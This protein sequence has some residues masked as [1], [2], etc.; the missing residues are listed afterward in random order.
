[1]AGFAVIAFLSLVGHNLASPES[2]IRPGR[3]FDPLVRETFAT[4]TDPA[5]RMTVL[6]TVNGKGP[7]P[8]TVD[9]GA[10]RSV[11]SDRLATELGISA[12]GTVTIEGLVGPDQ[13]DSVRLDHVSVGSTHQYA[14]D[15]AVLPAT[16]LG[17][18]GFLGTDM[19]QDRNVEFD[20]KRHRIT[21]TRSRGRGS[22]EDGTTIVVTARRRLGQ[23]VVTDASVAGHKVVA[24]I[25]TG[26]EN[27]VGNPA[28]R[29]ALLGD[30][31][32]GQLGE[33]IGVT[34]KSIPGEAGLVPQIRI[35]DLRLGNMPVVFANPHTFHL[36]KL[37]NVPAVLIGMDVLRLFNRVAID[38]TD[39]EVRFNIG[40]N[41]N[42]HTLQA[43]NR[44]RNEGKDDGG[45]RLLARADQAGAGL[46]S[47]RDLFRH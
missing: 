32:V 29:K 19:L 46:D 10:N 24:I 23:L 40:D 43:L 2:V 45:A 41:W 12:S 30:K 3:E 22:G 39:K 31:P 17:A 21:L 42:P 11:I 27:T 14:I 7:F 16:S 18:T 38:F 9:T 6:T 5:G 47:G 25:D 37:D 33:L 8:F 28:L 15:T 35:G 20:F 1:M 44:P 4:A 13:V 26:A 34:G 36:F